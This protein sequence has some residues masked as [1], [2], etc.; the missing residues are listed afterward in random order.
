[1]P[2]AKVVE[3]GEVLTI[4]AGEV[5]TIICC[6]CGLAHDYTFMS[7]RPRSADFRVEVNAKSTANTRRGLKRRMRQWIKHL[8]S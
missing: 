2:R 6:D 7:S 4:R 3:H 8:T 1:M 5:L